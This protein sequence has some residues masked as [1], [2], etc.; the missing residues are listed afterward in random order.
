MTVTQISSSSLRP[1]ISPASTQF[2]FVSSGQ[3]SM[4]HSSGIHVA[5]APWT[6]TPPAIA[7]HGG[8]SGTLPA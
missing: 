4:G 7:L 2:A 5:D 1:T 3:K 8:C 6:T